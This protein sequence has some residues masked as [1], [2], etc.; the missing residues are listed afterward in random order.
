[1]RLHLRLLVYRV[2]YIRYLI[3]LYYAVLDQRGDVKSML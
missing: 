3:S 1:M 2:S